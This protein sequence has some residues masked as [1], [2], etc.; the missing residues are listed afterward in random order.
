MHDISFFGY[1][2]HSVL[3]LVVFQIMKSR[4]KQNNIVL[5]IK[6]IKMTLNPILILITFD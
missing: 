6:L 1:N 5:D 3:H 2:G 4:I